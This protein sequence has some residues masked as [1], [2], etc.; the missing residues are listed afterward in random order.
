MEYFYTFIFC[1]IVVYLVYY[2]IV[3]SRKKGIE[4]FKSG[5]QV[6]Y[7][8][9]AYKLDLDKLNYKKFANSLALTNAFIMAF[10]IAIVEM[11]D[12]LIIKLLVAFVILIPLILL[13]Y[14]ILGKIYKK[15]EGK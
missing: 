1:F 3:V 12:S 11:F 14:Y 5:K 10:T 8:K 2:F 15:K 9:N 13:C 7:F 4:A 6:M